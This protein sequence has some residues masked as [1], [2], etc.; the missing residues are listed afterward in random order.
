[1]VKYVTNCRVP[2]VGPKPNMSKL[3][4]YPNTSQTREIELKPGTNS[5]GRSEAND[6]TIA[7]PS[8]SGNHCQITVSE[9]QVLVQDLGSTN[10]TF[11]HNARI[12]NARLEHGISLRFG[13]VPVIF[14]SDVPT[15]ATAPAPA[16]SV[17]RP[18]GLRISGTSHA[19][20]VEAAPVVATAVAEPPPFQAMEDMSTTPRFCKSH[21]KV[22]ARF[23]CPQ[24]HQAFCE[25]CTVA[26]TVTRGV[27]QQTC[28]VC[29]VELIPLNVRIEAAVQRGF[30][31]QL[32]G[33]VVYPFR[34]TGV[35]VLI[36]ATLVFAGLQ[37]LSGWFNLLLMAMA[38]GYVF[39]YMQN[40]IHSTASEETK[41]PELPGMDGLFG[42]FFTLVGT[43]L[44]SFGP[45]IGLAIARFYFDVEAISLT[46]ILIAAGLGSLYFPMALLASAMKDT[47]LAANPLIVLPAIFKVPVEYIVAALI[48]IGIFGIRI[49]G[50]AMS[51]V[52]GHVSMTTQSQ[53][54]M[55]TAFALRALWSFLS[56]YL[57]TVNMRVLGLLYATKQEKLN[58]Y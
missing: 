18:A 25:L 21:A 1:V 57:L 51:S 22:H 16:L 42:S 41:M 58:W 27:T 8:V 37:F 26:Q 43:V 46:L 55:F 50:G 19:A 48:M 28:R 15:T 33:S 56:V 3:V 49:L 30:F 11:I 4:V 35:L 54:V 36:A 9:G 47:A 44:M 39:A 12:E 29:H 45:A 40:I 34:G 23:A 7:D 32:P 20:P 24:C 14:Y 10:G 52:A 31:S 13:G 17:S 6:F 5:I 2:P 38:I 53:S